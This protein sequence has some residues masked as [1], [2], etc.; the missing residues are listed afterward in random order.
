MLSRR[1]VTTIGPMLT[2]L[3]NII[4][5]LLLV[6][7]LLY[8]INMITFLDPKI[9]QIIHVATVVILVI[10]LLLVITGTAPLIHIRG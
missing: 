3:V 9:K 8:S 1:T 4:I 6:G 7:L 2:L 10:W 5:V